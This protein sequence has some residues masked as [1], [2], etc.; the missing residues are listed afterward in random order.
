[1][2]NMFFEI[3]VSQGAVG[4]ITF[5]TFIIFVIVGIFK[6][7]KYL[8]YHKYFPLFTV[9]L[10][11]AASACMSTLVMAEIVYVTSPISTIFWISISC[12]NHYIS[13]EKAEKDIK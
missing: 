13:H 5:L 6:Y 2:H 4:L 1:M 3:L 12:L 7:G 10:S 8:W 11:I 9:I